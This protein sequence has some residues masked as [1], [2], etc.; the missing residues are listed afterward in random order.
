MVSQ[1]GLILQLL[2]KGTMIKNKTVIEMEIKGRNY[3][4][5][6]SPDSPLNEVME[7]LSAIH[8]CVAQRLKALEETKQVAEEAH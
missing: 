2:R 7:A 5:E 8:E 1:L 3:R 6:C 4:L